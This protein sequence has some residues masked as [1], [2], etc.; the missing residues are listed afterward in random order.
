MF[1]KLVLMSFARTELQDLQQAKVK[2]LLVGLQKGMLLNPLREG[3]IHVIVVASVL[4][5]KI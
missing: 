4:K 1:N 3:A 2:M 5:G